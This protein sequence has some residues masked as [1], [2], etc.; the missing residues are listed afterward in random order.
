MWVDEDDFDPEDFDFPDG[1]SQRVIVKE[2][3]GKLVQTFP[4]FQRD[5]Q[6]IRRP[7]EI[8]IGL[9]RTAGREP[10][11]FSPLSSLIVLDRL[12]TP[13]KFWS[14]VEQDF[15]LLEDLE[16]SIKCTGPISILIDRWQ[17]SCR[18]FRPGTASTS[19]RCLQFFASRGGAEKAAGAAAHGGAD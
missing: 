17:I 2:I 5:L 6:E 4:V 8:L 10:I 7:L 3:K 13:S 14:V 1:P 11:V 16:I 9:A 12:I 18:Q 15:R 19:N